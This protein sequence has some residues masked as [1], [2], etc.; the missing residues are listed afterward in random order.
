MRKRLKRRARKRVE[1]KQGDRRE[2]G[3]LLLDD[4]GGGGAAAAGGH[5]DNA[6]AATAD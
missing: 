5:G 1:G 2:V 4:G 3:M 6:A